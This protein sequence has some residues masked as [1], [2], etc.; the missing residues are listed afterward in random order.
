[1]RGG[2]RPLR[3]AGKALASGLFPRVSARRL[4][5]IVSECFAPRFMRAPGTAS[6]LKRLAVNLTRQEF[7]QLL[8]LY[9]ARAKTTTR[10][11]LSTVAKRFP[12]AV[13][14]LDLASEQVAGAT[15]EE[16]STVLYYK[17]LQWAG[18]SRNL[19]VAALERRLKKEGR[20]QEFLDLFKDM[21]GGEEWHNYR[22][23]D[24]VVE[25]LVPALAH[26]LYPNLFKT[27]SSF[28]TEASEVIRF[29]NDRVQEMLE[30]AREASG[31]DYIIFIID[32]VGQYV[33]SRPNLILNLD[34]LAKNLKTLG[35]GKVWIIGTAQQTLTEDDPRASLNS[36]QLFKLKDRFPIQID[37]EANDIKEICYTRLLGKSP[38]GAA[39]LGALFDQHGQALRHHTKLE[40]A[41][42]YGTDFD[43]ATFTN[44]YPFL[45]AHFD[46]LLHL[47]GAL[48]RSTGGITLAAKTIC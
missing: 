1:M 46:I 5:N 28:S 35:D 19:K 12:A 45:P 33:G 41:R 36:P 8:F 39:E 38:Q 26:Q 32:E 2:C 43:K 30:V 7:S 25:S 20:Y 31:K 29:E 37:L 21:A 17:V 16:V 40:D 13:L 22:N 3:Y 24:L 18:Y 47:L 44:L 34:G 42:A 6:A 23:D 10:Q 48:A 11:L 27:E 15:M 14:M 4:R 9:T